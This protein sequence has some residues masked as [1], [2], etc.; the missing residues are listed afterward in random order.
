MPEGNT[1]LSAFVYIFVN[2]LP[3]K[4]GIFMGVVRVLAWL[5]GAIMPKQL[6]S[7][8]KLFSIRLLL[9][10]LVL[11]QG[12]AIS[13]AQASPFSEGDVSANAASLGGCA[14]FP[15][16]NFWN[17]PVDNLPV[18]ARSDQWVN[19]IGRTT[20]FHMDFG[21]GTWDGGPI[22]IP[23]NVV[24][25]STPKVS[26]SF[27]YD[28]Q[29]DPGPYPIPSS[30]LIEYGS[31]HH[32][33][34]VDNSTCTLYELF[35]A[36]Y[37]GGTWSGGSGAIWNLNSNALRPDTW[38]SADAAGL[39]ILPG[40]VRYDEIL[41]GHIDHAI[42]FTAENTNGYIWPARHLTSDDPSAP[43][44]PPMGARF[45]LKASFNVSSY[46][47]AMQVILNAM[48]TY[49]IV[50]ADNGSDWYVSGAPD[51]RWDN[52]MLHLL[53]DLSGDDFE[54]VDTSKLMIAYD[55]GA[56]QP[57]SASVQVAVGG[58]SQGTYIVPFDASTRVSYASL[59]NGPVKIQSTNA[60]R[61]VASE[62][63][64]YSPDGGTTWTSYSELMGMPSNQLTTSYIFP[65]YNNSDLNSQLRFANVG[66]AN[67]NV[68]VTIGGQIKGT[69]PLIP[70][71]STRVSY[72]GLNAGP[73]KVTSSGNVPIIASMRV[74]YFD[75]GLSKWTSF[76]EL[77][78]LPSTKLTTSYV[79]PWYNNAD[80]NSQLRFGNVGTANTTVTVTIGGQ[81]RGTYPLAP[82]ASQRVS[83][84][85]LNAGPVK[86]TSSGNVPII[87]SMRVA[88]T[89]DN[90][91]TWPEFSEMMGMPSS[92]LSTSYSF[93]VYNNLDLNT[94][95][96]FGNVGTAN[97]TVTVTIGG[98]VQGVYPLSPNASQR[99][100]YPI[101]SGPVVIQSS[102]NVPIIASQRVAYFDSGPGKWTSFAEMMGLPSN[103]LTTT[104]LFPWY[105]NVDLNTQLRFGVP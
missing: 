23:Y 84:P 3:D 63:V 99:V 74:A 4:I 88:Y 8:L 66:N 93:P 53:D 64:A 42:R 85:G 100:N 24:G 33:L 45:R 77:M 75:S 9:V 38:T 14:L 1:S 5:G 91:V 67:T 47:A 34:I 17:T 102:G 31:D 94:Q 59:N 58:S 55:S 103:Q 73:I 86:V 44:I 56:A 95:L 90:G 43:Q 60:T 37:S 105:N 35:D 28:E 51:E 30:P 52:D 16:N 104:Y 46:P 50:L 40:L 72:N 20:G 82:N 68:T 13:S 18:H 27:Y 62:R 32:I 57:P 97:T 101:N 7:P 79:F 80:I 39:P 83:F 54:A 26:V 6:H 61:I 71:Q 65:W 41:S 98:V 29:S 36:S 22:G 48:K 19:T 89:P 87:A 76:S 21:S 96:R 92:S 2:S 10:V 81:I 12:Q 25:A 78:G 49:G 11:F 69:Y 70:S 15:A